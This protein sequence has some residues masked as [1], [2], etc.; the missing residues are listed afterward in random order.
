MDNPDLLEEKEEKYVETPF[1]KPSDALITG[2]IKGVNCVLLARHGRKHSIYPSAVNYRANIWAMKQEGCTHILVTTA[3]GS[4]QEQYKPGDIVFL[5]QFVDRTYRREQT[6]F[7][8]APG[9]PPGVCHVPMHTPFCPFTRE[10]LIS[11]AKDLGIKHHETGTN[12]TI[13]GP[14]FSSKSESKLYKSWGCHLI[15]MSTVPEVALAK[16]AGICYASMALVTDYDSWREVGNEEHVNVDSVLKTF[17]ENGEK[18][19]KI[20]LH[21]IPKIAEKDWTKI[22][23]DH[24]DLIVGSNMLHP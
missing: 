9:S 18:A 3:S 5:D 7:D 23:K 12:V 13:E 11:V 14:R 15:N 17:K 2:K 21:A 6:F 24:A 22:L 8:G 19:M 16:E 4:L 1:G 10:I 20:L